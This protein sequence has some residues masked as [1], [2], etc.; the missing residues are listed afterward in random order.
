MISVLI[1]IS[2]KVNPKVAHLSAHLERQM[3]Q[4]SVFSLQ[5]IAM[6]TYAWPWSAKTPPCTS[7]SL[8]DSLFSGGKINLRCEDR[9]EHVA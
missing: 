5:K 9:V 3:Q 4:L 8:G 1:A 7:C 6:V 2:Y